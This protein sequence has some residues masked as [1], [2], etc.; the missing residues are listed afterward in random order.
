MVLVINLYN[1]LEETRHSDLPVLSS[2]LLY[3]CLCLC[4]CFLSMYPVTDICE[5]NIYVHVFRY[6]RG[7]LDHT[8]F[9]QHTTIA[10]RVL[11]LGSP[12]VTGSPDSDHGDTQDRDKRL[13][14]TREI[15][16]NW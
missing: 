16:G 5:H 6:T 8:C 3:L 15:E 14:C 1:R 10:R 2:P 13:Q 4:L 9:G 11:D 12:L 7:F